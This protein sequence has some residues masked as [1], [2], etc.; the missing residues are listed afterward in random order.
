MITLICI[1]NKSTLKQHREKKL[2]YYADMR[3]RIVSLLVLALLR[4]FKAT[5]KQFSLSFRK[6]TTYE[7][8]SYCII[9]TAFK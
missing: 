4:L 6:N 9:P 8:Y 1:Y 3:Y 2:L 7:K 5:R